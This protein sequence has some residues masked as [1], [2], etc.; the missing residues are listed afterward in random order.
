MEK[1]IGCQS[2]EDFNRFLGEIQDIALPKKL[3]V[4][5]QSG[6]WPNVKIKMIDLVD[7]D[8]IDK[9]ELP[10]TQYLV[11]MILSQVFLEEDKAIKFYGVLRKYFPKWNLPFIPF[12]S[13]FVDEG[14]DLKFITFIEMETEEWKDRDIQE[15]RKY[16]CTPKAISQRL[17]SNLT[18]SGLYVDTSEAIAY[19]VQLLY[20]LIIAPE[21]VEKKSKLGNVISLS[22]IS[23]RKLND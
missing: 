9:V 5:Y 23:G 19:Y 17:R 10:D 2:V 22:Q 3:T 18:P 1:L 15:W 11:A 14:F 8:E 4:K 6:V 13:L 20:M 21:I 7:A 12:F 16:A